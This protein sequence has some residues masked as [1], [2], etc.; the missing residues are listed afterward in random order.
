MFIPDPES[1]FS[2]PG[3]R[4]KNIPDPGPASNNLR[5]LTPKFFSKLSEI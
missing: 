4:V 3:S 2:H 5:F 1:E